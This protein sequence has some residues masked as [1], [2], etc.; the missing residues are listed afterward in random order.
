MRLMLPKLILVVFASVSCTVVPERTAE[1]E[2]VEVTWTT[3]DFRREISQ[4]VNCQS[5]G[6]VVSTRG[7]SSGETV[8]VTVINHEDSAYEVALYGTVGIHGE[9]RILWEEGACE[10]FTPSGRKTE[11]LPA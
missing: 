8:R 10:G 5:I 7:Y 3:P 6:L 9:A 11:P 1:K 2:I 4:T